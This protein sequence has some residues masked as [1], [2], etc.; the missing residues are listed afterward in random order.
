MYGW[1]R[2]GLFGDVGDD[3]PDGVQPSSFDFVNRMKWNSWDSKRGMEKED[4]LK[5]V[6]NLMETLLKENGLEYKIKQ[7]A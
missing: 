1:A 7:N 3:K 6:I 2:Q 4:A 5:S